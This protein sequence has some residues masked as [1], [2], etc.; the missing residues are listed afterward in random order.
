MR[1]LRVVAGLEELACAHTDISQGNVMV[2]YP[3]LS[4]A[5]RPGEPYMSDAAAPDGSKGT[6]GYAHPSADDGVSLWG[7]SGDRYAAA[8]LAT[9]ILV[10]ADRGLASL[11]TEEGF[12]GL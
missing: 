6:F 11:A 2:D 12:F 7:P 3:E 5:L 4:P 10:L 8:I 9:E 1:F